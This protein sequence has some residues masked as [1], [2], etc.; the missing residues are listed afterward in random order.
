MTKKKIVNIIKK[1]KTFLI[2]THVNPDPDA[3][4]SELAFA[5][6]LRS[7]GKQVSIVNEAETVKRLTFL[8]ADSTAWI[9][10]ARL[11]SIV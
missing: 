7:L 2:S 10:F 9:V 5:A 11:L 6:Y 1:N 8:I 4:C 3:I